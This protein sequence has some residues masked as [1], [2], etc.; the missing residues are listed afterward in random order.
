MLTDFGIAKAVDESRNLTNFGIVGTPGYMAPEIWN[1]APATPA[2]DQYATAVMA[3]E[4]L[5]GEHPLDHHDGDWRK[6]HLERPPRPLADVAP[7]ID[8]AVAAAIETALDKEPTSRHSDVRAF[9]AASA[10]HARQAFQQSETVTHV[11]V[12]APTAALAAEHLTA[13]T[14]LSDQTI[15]HLTEVDRT[16][17]V[18]MRRRQ[19]R[20]ALVGRRP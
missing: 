2:S 13:T 6:A 7:A 10:A 12:A 17:I 14:Q 4:M 11:L 15:S 3:Y 9:A 19:A 16:E 1:G 5:T 20:Q 8:R 18:R